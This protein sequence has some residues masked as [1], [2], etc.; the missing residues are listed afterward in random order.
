MGIIKFNRAL[1][2]EF[3][4]A[5][6]PVDAQGF[7][8]VLFDLN[9]TLHTSARR[10]SRGEEHFFRLVFREI[11]FL[12]K[13]AKARVAVFLGAFL[14]SVCSVRVLQCVTH[15]VEVDESGRRTSEFSKVAHSKIAT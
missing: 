14:F 13:V 6:V 9:A 8:F 10:A 11:D 2:E 4:S 5:F 1:Q 7:D 15:T 3:P 12:L